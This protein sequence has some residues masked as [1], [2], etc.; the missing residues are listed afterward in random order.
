M[1]PAR[2]LESV[3][4]DHAVGL[5]RVPRPH[6]PPGRRGHRPAVRLQGDARTPRTGTRRARRS[7]PPAAPLRRPPRLSS[8]PSARRRPRSSTATV[9]RRTTTTERVVVGVW[10]ATGAYKNGKRKYVYIT[11]SLKSAHHDKTK[12]S[13]D[14]P[15]YGRQDRDRGFVERHVQQRD[16]DAVGSCHASAGEPGRGAAAAARPDVRRDAGA[17]RRGCRRG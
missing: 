8:R 17:R 7:S 1:R 10:H 2:R 14:I 12:H 3:R 6:R 5:G 9:P 15:V 16:G 4:G 11:P 13:D